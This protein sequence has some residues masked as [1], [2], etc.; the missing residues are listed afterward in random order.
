MT[1]QK[2]P[3]YRSGLLEDQF[4]RLLGHKRLHLQ[5]CTECSHV[6]YPPG[7]VCPRCISDKWRWEPMAGTARIVSWTV[8]HRQYFAEFPPPHTVVVAALDEGPLIT[9]DLSAID[10]STLHVDLPV[11]LEF[12]QAESEGA[13]YWIYRWT[14]GST[15]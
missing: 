13:P 10:P 14:L 7:P 15:T 8:F 6:W 2:R 5:R 9:A 1:W 3:P 12:V 4:W 11:S